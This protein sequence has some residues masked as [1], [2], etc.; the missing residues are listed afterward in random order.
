MTTAAAAWRRFEAEIVGIHSRAENDRPVML[1][2]IHAWA[3]S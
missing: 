2:E 3:E 1:S